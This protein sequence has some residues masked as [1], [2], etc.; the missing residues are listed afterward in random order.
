MTNPEMN[1]P[2]SLESKVKVKLLDP[3]G[4]AIDGLKYH[5]MDGEKIVAKGVTDGQGNISPLLSKIGTSLTLYVERFANAEMKMVKTFKPWAADFS[6]KLLSGKVKEE[7]PLVKD[8]GDKGQYK[9]K[10]YT[11]KDKDTLGRIASENGT[12][13]QAIATLNGMKVSDI[14]HVGKVLK[15]PTQKDVAPSASDSTAPQYA[16]PAAK[17]APPPPASPAPSA[18]GAARAPLSQTPPVKNDA[19]VSKSS[20]TQTPPASAPVET[21]KIEDRGENGTPK[22]TINI[23]CDQSGCIKLGDVGQLIEEINIRLSGFG[24][25]LLA[26]KKLNEYTTQTEKAV[27]QFQRDY[28]GVAETGKVCGAV[29]LALDA[30]ASKYPLP[31]ESMKCKCNKCKG[32]G[33]GYTDSAKADFWKKKDTPYIG[34]EFPGMHRSL[35]WMFRAA[36]FYVGDKDKALGYFYMGISSAYRCWKDNKVHSRHTTNHMGNALDVQFRHGNEKTRCEGG[37]LQKLRDDIFIKQM[38]GQM[39]WRDS[40]LLSL[41]PADIAPSWVHFDVRTFSSEYQQDKYYATTQAGVD[42]EPLVEM[43]KRESR[44]KLINCGGILPKP[45]VIKDDRV[46]IASL[47]LSQLGLEFIKGWESYGDK[48]YDDSEK[49][50]TIGWGHLIAKSSCAS[51]AQADD[52]RY[53]QYKNG[54]TAERAAEIL[55]KDIARITMNVEDYVQVPLYQQEYDALISLAFNTGGFGKFPKLLSKLNTKDYSGCCNEFADIA[56]HGTSGLVKR[57]QAEMKIFRNNVYDSKH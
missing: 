29:L 10:T 52:N 49:Y 37:V 14:L 31:L 48:P 23:I 18:T 33:S 40:N 35:L 50:C 22:A 24:G 7:I 32:F 51:L 1:D 57:R 20:E 15:I 13:V 21:K 46:P 11:V 5:I 56:N 45:A 9:R 27:K 34:T 12:T 25:T 55:E 54:I 4:R 47:K 38:G 17:P 43:A 36:L 53:E 26:P 16:A 42:G 2:E 6:I 8:S 3:L 39:A 28:M 30:F 41:E 44:L 19:P